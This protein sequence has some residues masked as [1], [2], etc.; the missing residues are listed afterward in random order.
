MN[1]KFEKYANKDFKKDFFNLM[2]KLVYD[3]TM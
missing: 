1:I 3:E 2:E